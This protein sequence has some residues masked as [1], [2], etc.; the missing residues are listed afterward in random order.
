MTVLIAE[1]KIPR[2]LSATTAARRLSRWRAARAKWEFD[3]AP[4]ARFCGEC[5]GGLTVAVQSY[6]SRSR[7]VRATAR[8]SGLA[9][10]CPR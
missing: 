10:L 4:G 6:E 3:N 8:Q 5:G 7:S 2:E 1:P 9:L